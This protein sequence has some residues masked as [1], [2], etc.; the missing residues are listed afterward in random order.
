MTSPGTRG[1]HGWKRY[2]GVTYVATTAPKPQQLHSSSAAA[3]PV[4]LSHVFMA[5]RVPV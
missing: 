4:M 2:E 5:A 3:S 1:D